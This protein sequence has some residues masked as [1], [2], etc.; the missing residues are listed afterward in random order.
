[1]Q[2]SSCGLLLWYHCYTV[3][4]TSYGMRSGIT[5]NG[6]LHHTHWKYA[7]S[8]HPDDGQNAL[9]VSYWSGVLFDG[10]SEMYSNDCDA[11]QKYFSDAFHLHV[12]LPDNGLQASADVRR[13]EL[14]GIHWFRFH[15]DDWWF[16]P[17]SQNH[18]HPP[19]APVLPM[20]KS[21][22]KPYLHALS[23][24]DGCPLPEYPDTPTTDPDCNLHHKL[25]DQI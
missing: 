13:T 12:T 1:M 17:S 5:G 16:L 15:T 14:P 25:N 20:Q 18:T 22:V 23:S 8:A 4:L 24:S 6:T 21:P 3:F 9:P 19:A 2:Y 11:V 7:T 10:R